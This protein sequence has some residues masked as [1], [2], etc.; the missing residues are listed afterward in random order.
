MSKREWS[1]EKEWEYKG[2]ECIVTYALN[3]YCTGFRCGYVV[4]K[5]K[6]Y[7]EDD[8]IGCHG[9]V[10]WHGYHDRLG[11]TVIGFDCAHYGDTLD[12]CT[13]EYCMGE[14]ES[15]VEQILKLKENTDD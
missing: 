12:N 8:L 4:L 7:V 6:E 10:T 5:D 2:Y 11:K 13:L 15:I 1:I 3:A 9:G 14:C